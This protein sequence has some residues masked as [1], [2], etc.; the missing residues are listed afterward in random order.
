MIFAMYKDAR[1]EWRWF[2]QADNKEK[3]ANSGEGYK[4][5]SDCL[6]AINLVKS[7]GQSTAVYDNEVDKIL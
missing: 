4:N 5:R 7:T 3:I 2:L 6:H 1:G